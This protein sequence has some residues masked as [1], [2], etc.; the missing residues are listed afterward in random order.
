MSYRVNAVI[1]V[2]GP[3]RGR[4]FRP[5]SL[6]LP[7]P[8]FPIANR[9]VIRHQIDA[10]TKVEGLHTI[11]LMG[12]YREATFQSFIKKTSDE[13]SVKIRYLEEAQPLGTAGGLF[14]FKNI[15]LEDGPQ[16]LFVL[17]SDICCTFPLKGLLEFHVGHGHQCTMLGLKIP[18]EYATN[19]GCFVADETTH[20]MLHYIEK[21]S[22][23]VSDTI[24]GG[25]YCLSPIVLLS[26]VKRTPSKANMF[27]PLDIYQDSENDS[28]S[29][30]S[31]EKGVI[32]P[33]VARGSVYVYM[34]NDFWKTIKTCGSALKCSEEYLKYFQVHQPEIITQNPEFPVE[35]AISVDP[36]AHIDK[37][38]KLGPNVTIG[39]NTRIGA[40]VR[41]SNS[42]ILNNVML[43]DRCCVINSIICSDSVIGPWCRVEGIESGNPYARQGSAD[44]L[45]I[46]IFGM[47][48]VAEPEIVVRNC[49]V[50]PHKHLNHNYFNE[51]LL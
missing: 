3:T 16:Y 1:L 48:V 47:G 29:T 23:F 14:Y 45:G 49:I 33:L 13:L 20:K 17:H 38:A 15:I 10:C 51:I 28:E 8:L 5:I 11:F 7:K 30:F 35:G 6:D 12:G 36:T 42:I 40:G 19:Y 9:P 27:N 4:R 2:G 18:R 31:L 46:T 43:K 34:Y 21:P 24:N 44:R 37:T 50:M 26:P 32:P 25:I 41:V 22:T 39:A